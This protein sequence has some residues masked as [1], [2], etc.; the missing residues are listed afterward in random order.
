MFEVVKFGDVGSCGG[1]FPNDRR[2]FVHDR[3]LAQSQEDIPARTKLATILTA[4]IAIGRASLLANIEHR[5]S[6]YDY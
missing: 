5:N 6:D 3:P 2:N 4:L 1:V